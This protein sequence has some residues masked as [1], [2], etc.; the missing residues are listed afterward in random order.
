MVGLG[1]SESVVLACDLVKEDASDGDVGF[2]VGRP[3]GV[4]IDI[5]GDVGIG[6]LCVGGG[7][8]AQCDDIGVLVEVG[9]AGDEVGIGRVG[10][11]V[12][13]AVGINDDLP[14]HCWIRCNGRGDVIPSRG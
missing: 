7:D 8:V 10:C 12:R 14:L 2:G 3:V 11:C 6:T 1:R 4:D 13:S 5:R 9:D